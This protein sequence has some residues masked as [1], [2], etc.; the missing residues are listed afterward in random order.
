VSFRLV[1]LQLDF[2]QPQLLAGKDIQSLAA[3]TRATKREPL[4]VEL[5]PA[6]LAARAQ[7]NNEKRERRARRQAAL[8]QSIE[9]APKK[10]RLNAG[11]FA[12]AHRDPANSIGPGRARDVLHLPHQR[13]DQRLFVHVAIVR[14]R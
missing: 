12:H 8:A 1:N 11:Q 14:R 13:S 5:A 3:A 2:F 10:L 9:R 4:D 7:W 6:G